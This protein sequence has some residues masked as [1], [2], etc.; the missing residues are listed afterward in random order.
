MHGTEQE[1]ASGCWARTN[2]YIWSERTS[3]Q[4]Q[5]GKYFFST[6]KTRRRKRRSWRR[7]R[8]FAVCCK[9]SLGHLSF[10]PQGRGPH[11]CLGRHAVFDTA[12]RQVLFLGNGAAVGC[13]HCAVALTGKRE[14]TLLLLFVP[15]TA[16]KFYSRPT[17]TSALCD[18]IVSRTVCSKKSDHVR[19]TTRLPVYHGSCA[20]CTGEAPPARDTQVACSQSQ[21]KGRRVDS[22][23]VDESNFCLFLFS[24]QSKRFKSSYELQRGKPGAEKV[25]KPFPA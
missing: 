25:Q 11:A 21:N 15:S 20:C 2:V 1:L 3:I 22:K 10:P 23:T 7:C 4:L 9:K 14:M 19:T 16:M 6:N 8:R 13:D 17:T 5:S 12:V 18:F 24:L